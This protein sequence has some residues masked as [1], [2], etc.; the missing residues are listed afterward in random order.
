[1]DLSETG[2]RDPTQETIM[3]AT[4]VQGSL[5]YRRPNVHEI[6]TSTATACCQINSEQ[7]TQSFHICFNRIEW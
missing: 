2:G 6:S 5:A 3:P 7:P 4:V 1:M